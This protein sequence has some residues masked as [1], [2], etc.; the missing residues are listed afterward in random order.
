MSKALFHSAAE[1]E[2]AM[3]TLAKVFRNDNAAAFTAF[4]PD[5]LG[6]NTS[7]GGLRVFQF[8]AADLSIRSL[9][10]IKANPAASFDH[11]FPT[12]DELPALS[13]LSALSALPA[14][15]PVHDAADEHEKSALER[16]VRERAIQETRAEIEAQLN[17]QIG[18]LR[19]NLS[20]TIENISGLSQEITAKLEIEAV[21][22]ALEIA[23]KV[24]AREV[25]TDR[26][27]ILS[28]TKNALSKLNSRTLASVH[29]HP[30]DLAYIQEH[31]GKLNF[32]GSLEL[33]EDG[34]ITPG[35]CLIHTDAGDIDGR[36]E[37]QFDEIVYGLLGDASR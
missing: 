33:I 8:P 27:I 24:V 35:G 17:A 4:R 30:D 21:E 7:G 13:A 12:I 3:N 6:S 28:V 18:D 2:A 22:L 11:V 14:L 1:T 15:P 10:S 31:R 5:E 20:K 37:S 34:S 19:E 36:I 16:A 25:S 9:S 32:H 23:R 26:E 29:L